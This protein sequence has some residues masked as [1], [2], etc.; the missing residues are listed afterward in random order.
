MFWRYAPHQI[1]VENGPWRTIADKAS[2]PTT[3]LKISFVKLTAFEADKCACNALPE[4]TGNIE[5]SK[6]QRVGN[7]VAGDA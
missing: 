1:Q 2:A 6:Y 4:R 5:I 7:I 3:E